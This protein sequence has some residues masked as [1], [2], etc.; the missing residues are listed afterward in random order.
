MTASGLAA[1]AHENLGDK[2][3]L[4]SSELAQKNE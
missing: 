2:R 4:I 1:G 3:H